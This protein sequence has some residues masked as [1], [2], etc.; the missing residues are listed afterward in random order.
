VVDAPLG[1]LR[2]VC[3]QGQAASH[4]RALGERRPIVREPWTDHRDR[5]ALV[6]QACSARKSGNTVS[7]NDDPIAHRSN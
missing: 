7:D 2:R 4:E 5:H 1:E 3:E 6:G